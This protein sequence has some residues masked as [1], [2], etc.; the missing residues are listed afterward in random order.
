MLWTAAAM[1]GLS[2]KTTQ[3]SIVPLSAKIEVED[4]YTII[5]NGQSEAYRY[6]EGK[7]E[8]EE[9]FDYVFDVIQKRYDD[10]WKSIKNMHRLHPQYNGKAGARDQVMYFELGFNDLK[11]NKLLSVINSSL[12][13]GVGTTDKEFRD[14]Q[15]ILY[16]KDAGILA[17]YNKV[18]ITQH[19]QYEQGILKE[20][21]E[22][23]KEKNGKET[24]FMKNEETA[25]F[26]LKGNVSRASTIYKRKA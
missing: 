19:Y 2:C 11:D 8:R 16:I 22:L 15:L 17:P 4:T 6:V 20:T 3:K 9:L 10:K 12:G 21:V 5:W 24:Y 7:W 23:L 18:R 14:Q 1:M 25:Y 26:Y 13:N